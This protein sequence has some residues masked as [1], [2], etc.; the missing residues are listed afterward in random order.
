MGGGNRRVL[1]MKMRV[2][3]SVISGREGEMRRRSWR[4]VVESWQRCHGFERVEDGMSEETDTE[5]GWLVHTDRA[6]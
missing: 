1:A 5:G 2:Y 4:A 3:G 6:A